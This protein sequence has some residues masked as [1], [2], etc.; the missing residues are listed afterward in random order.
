[1]VTRRT[2]SVIRH[3]TR[4]AAFAVVLLAG[5]S[6]AFGQETATILGTV[7]DA[8]GAAV[9]GANVTARKTDTQ[10]S[11]AATTDSDGS[12]RIPGLFVGNYE[13]RV[14]HEGFQAAVRT[15]LVLTVDLQ[16]VT[17]F[18]L[19]IGS[20][21]QT[22]EV[23]GEAPLVDTTTSS[24]G[25]LVDSKRMEDLPLNG[26]NYIDLSLMQVG[27]NEQKNG[28]HQVGYVGDYVV[29]NGATVRSNNYL[30]DGANM[31]N[32]WGVSSASVTNSTLG[33]DGIREYKVVTNAFKAE[34]GMTAGSQMLMVSKGGTNSFHGDVFEYLRNSAL[35][36][37]NPFDTLVS[38][39]GKRLPEFQRNNFGASLGGPI[40]KNKI[41]FNAVYE[42]LRQ[43]RALRKLPMFSRRIA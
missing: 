32:A 3:F 1:M 35:D 18:T 14:E 36:A 37:K 7:K 20:V 22:V 16:A 40:R 6:V 5:S 27:V 12:Y 42:G 39:G 23:T 43:S 29:S 41:F 2:L 13:V 28:V 8:S 11:R 33:V 17:N 4:W 21:S 19:Q 34:Y 31:T 26:R 25:G 24:L 9:A 15:G 10:Q 30:I 38:S